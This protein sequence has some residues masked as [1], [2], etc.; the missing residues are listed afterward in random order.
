MATIALFLPSTLLLYGVAR[1]WHRY[2]G[3]DWHLA[4]QNGLVPVGAGLA[5][6]GVLAIRRVSGAGPLSWAIAGGSAI[7]LGTRPIIHPLLLLAA[8][9]VIFLV[10]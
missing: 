4:L 2:R 8:G 6:A 1:L 7:I 9:A 5:L 10:A 3:R